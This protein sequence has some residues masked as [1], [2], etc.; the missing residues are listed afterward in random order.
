MSM[1]IFNGLI[2]RMKELLDRITPDRAAG[3]DHLDA[4]IASRAPAATALS[5]AVWSDSLATLLGNTAGRPVLTKPPIASGIVSTTVSVTSP[6]AYVDV[7]DITSGDGYMTMLAVSGTSMD[8]QLII[9]GVAVGSLPSGAG[10]RAL[11]G[12]VLSWPQYDGSSVSAVYQ[13][14]DAPPV[15]FASSIKV[16]A[17]GSGSVTLR[18]VRTR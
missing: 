1:A 12:L 10:L 2:G 4:D 14:V 9:D 17:K 7:L 5:N 18:Y 6:G 8:V 3:L 11:V 16:R 13:P 15:F